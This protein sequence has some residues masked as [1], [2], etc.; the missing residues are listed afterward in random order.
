MQVHFKN[1]GAKTAVRCGFVEGKYNY[2]PHIHQ[3]PE[4]VYVEDGEMDIVTEL[5]KV[6]MRAG[7]IAVLTPFL[8]HEFHTKK[9][10]KRWLAVFSPDFLHGF[11][12]SEAI[13]GTASGCVFRASDALLGYIK[14]R[15]ADSKETF[16]E[17]TD[18]Q[19]RSFKLLVMAVYEEFLKNHTITDKSHQR[20]LP[21]ILHYISLHSGEQLSLSS[22]GAALGYSPKYVSL[23]LSDI[24]GVNLFYLINSFRAEKAKDLLVNSGLKIIDIAYECGYANEKSFYRA[25]LQVTGM[26]PGQYRKHRRTFG[27]PDLEADS[28]HELTVMK[29]EQAKEKRMMRLKKS[30]ERSQSAAPT[31][32]KGNKNE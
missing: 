6:T 12:P 24:D 26:T 32:E 15:L 17:M 16:Y 13:Y 18:E 14:P 30:K 3:F 8:V 22:I 25:F 1:F 2:T 27:K 20:A 4:I 5:G 31:E 28:Y 11:L 7:D 9:Y 29:K 23:C 19:M 10:V 21:T